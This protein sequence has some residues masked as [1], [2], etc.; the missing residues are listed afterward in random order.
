MSGPAKWGSSDIRSNS[1]QIEAVTLKRFQNRLG[2][3]VSSWDA[4][5]YFPRRK[6]V[7][8]ICS[9]RVHGEAEDIAV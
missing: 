6:L 5:R 1:H 7:G 4:T 2:Y 3:A 9:S 8:E